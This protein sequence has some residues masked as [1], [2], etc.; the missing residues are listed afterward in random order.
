MAVSRFS[1]AAYADLV[2]SSKLQPKERRVADAIAEHEPM[3]REE[4]SAVT[5]MKEGS[6]CGRVNKLM[7]R[8]LVVHHGYRHNQA[9]DKLNEVVDLVADRRAMYQTTLQLAQKRDAMDV[10]PRQMVLA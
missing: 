2:D 10:S 1:R 3:T 4:I 6:A 9:T 5:G 7:E 8:G